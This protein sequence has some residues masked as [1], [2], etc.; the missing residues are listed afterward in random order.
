MSTLLGPGSVG[1]PSS[2]GGSLGGGPHS[3][4]PMAQFGSPAPGGPMTAAGLLNDYNPPMNDPF[5]S[6]NPPNKQVGPGSVA[7][8]PMMSHSISRSGDLERFSFPPLEVPSQA[9]IQKELQEKKNSHGQYIF[10]KHI[11]NP[12]SIFLIDKLRYLYL[13]FSRHLLLLFRTCVY[14]LKTSINEEYS[15]L[16]SSSEAGNEEAQRRRQEAAEGDDD[17]DDVY[18][19]GDNGKKKRFIYFEVI[20]IVFI[21]YIHSI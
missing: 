21:V 7:M 2:V 5:R 3:V 15:Y 17:E 10:E 13:Q 8:H 11:Q 19:T 18:Q 16:D 1:A 9:K 20:L 6:P 4:D 14:S 12:P